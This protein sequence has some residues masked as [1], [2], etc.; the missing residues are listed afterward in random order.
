ML[1]AKA[2]HSN[3]YDGQ[4]LAPVLEEYT[5]QSGVIP[6][7]VYMDKGYKGIA[8]STNAEFLNPVKSVE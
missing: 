7:R 5:A 1:H 4:T 2:L 6:E 3:P 8:I